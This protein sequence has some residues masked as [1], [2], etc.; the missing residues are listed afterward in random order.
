MD[1]HQ[2]RDLASETAEVQAD[3][4]LLERQVKILSDGLLKCQQF[5]PRTE[6][7]LPASFTSMFIQNEQR[8]SNGASTAL[9]YIP[10]M[11]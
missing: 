3:R 11:I 4:E 5:K 10:Q 8:L 6:T 1:E 7:I 2:L 9:L